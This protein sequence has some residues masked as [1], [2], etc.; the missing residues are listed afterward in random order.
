MGCLGL[1]GRS[2]IWQ[3]LPWPATT[4]GGL[5]AQPGAARG[6]PGSTMDGLGLPGANR[7]MA[8]SSLP[9]A[10]AANKR[11]LGRLRNPVPNTAQQ[12]DNR[13]VGLTPAVH[14][15]RVNQGQLC[16]LVCHTR[17]V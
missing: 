2:V 8:G 12:R 17:L 1:P 11:K 7:Q 10:L 9:F 16:G 14:H 6:P 3:G 15:A 13:S 5:R 4:Y